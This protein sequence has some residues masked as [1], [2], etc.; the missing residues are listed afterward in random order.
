MNNVVKLQPKVT[1][2]EYFGGCPHCGETAGYINIGRDH[3]FVCDRHKTK[4]WIGSNLF[5]SWRDED[6]EVWRRNDY[7]LQN[8]MTVEPIHPQPT[9]KD[10]ERRRAMDRE[11]AMHKALDAVVESPTPVD[12]ANP[13]GLGDL[14]SDFEH[15]PGKLFILTGDG[16]AYD[17]DRDEAYAAFDSYV[18]G[19]TDAIKRLLR[20]APSR[21]VRS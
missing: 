10:I 21:S 19:D 2:D 5:S 4:W 17:L 11:S 20:T 9:A 8:Y 6:E 16:R 18:A 7:Q 12:P 3:W 1:T 14:L 15:Q 13:L